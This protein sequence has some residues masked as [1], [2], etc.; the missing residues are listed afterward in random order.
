MIIQIKYRI[1][2]FTLILLACTSY[3]YADKDSTVE[4]HRSHCVGC[5]ARMTGGDGTLVYKRDDSIV[6]NKQELLQ[7]VTY[8][9]NGAHTDWSETEVIS[10]TNFLNAVIYN[11]PE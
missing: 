2:L 8:C 11:F 9:S 10:V 1:A 6:H 7:R 3:S 4:L 5:H